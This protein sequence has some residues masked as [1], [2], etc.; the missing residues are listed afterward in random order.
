MASH[1]SL[2]RFVEHILVELI[3]VMKRVA[4]QKR[5]SYLAVPD[6]IYIFLAFAAVARVE[7]FLRIF[8]VKHCYRKRQP[9]VERSL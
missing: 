5:I 9:A 7:G 1:I 4:V 6:F 2:S 3:A 8:A